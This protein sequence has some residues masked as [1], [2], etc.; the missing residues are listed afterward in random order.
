M[1]NLLR[2]AADTRQP[3]ASRLRQFANNRAAATSLTLAAALAVASMT[4]PAEAT[5]CPDEDARLLFHSCRGPSAVELLL[6]PEDADR[7]STGA[8][9]DAL[10]VSGAYTGP[11][12]RAGGHPNP[13]GLFVDDGRVVSPNLARMDGVLVI[14]PEAQPEIY[15]RERV[16]LRGRTADL[17]DPDQRLDFA[18]WASEHGRS[19]MQSHLLITDGQLDVHPQFD[20]PT[21]R[22]RMLFIGTDGWGVYQ[23]A[24]AV[25]LFDAAFELQQ[26]YHPRM[27]INLDMGSFDYCIVTR[28]RTAEN[29]GVL[30]ATQT[31]KLS[32][33]LRFSHTGS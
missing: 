31:D 33:L 6:L 21:A 12:T 9:G 23:T 30:G 2:N 13:V 5:L 25:T 4:M 26:R 14:G 10:V 18:D 24:E 11:D 7:L 20:A 1:S 28:G 17:T 8:D 3:V 27:A 19:V 32:N 16:P 15:H 29:C 22:R